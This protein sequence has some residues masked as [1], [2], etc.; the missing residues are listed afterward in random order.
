[1]DIQETITFVLLITLGLALA[2]LAHVWWQERR[3]IHDAK[4]EIARTDAYFASREP[5]EYFSP[6]ELKRK[7]SRD[8]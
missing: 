8:D 6:E 5:L 2:E 1:M 7:L 3:A 4:S